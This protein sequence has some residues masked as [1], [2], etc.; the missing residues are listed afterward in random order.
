MLFERCNIPDVV[1]CKP[2]VFKDQRG[3]F[4]ETFRQDQ[5]DAFLGFKIDFCQDNES[6]SQFGVLRGLHYQKPPFS[7]TKLVRVIAGRILDVAVDLRKD[8]AT[9]GKHVA[10]ELSATNK[11]QLLVPRGFA[12]GFV[13]LSENAVFNYKCDAYYAPDSE[14]GVFYNDPLLNIN[15]S[16]N[17]ADLILSDKDLSLPLFEAAAAFKE[18]DT[19]YT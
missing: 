19:L 4:M 2:T 13:V 14:E 6:Q 16:L 3:Y 8:S 10:V 17:E 9:F 15:W 7:Q 18:S 1:L 11:Y 12:H 5:L